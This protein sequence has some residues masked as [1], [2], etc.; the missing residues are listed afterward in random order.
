MLAVALLVAVAAFGVFA[1]VAVHRSNKPYI[2][3][4]PFEEQPARMP[5]DYFASG[6]SV[7]ILRQLAR[8]ADLRVL[9]VTSARLFAQ[10]GGSRDVARSLGVTH[11]LEGS[12]R[13]Q[14][15][16]V[17]VSAHLIRADDRSEVWGEQYDRALGEIFT[18]QQD[19]TNAVAQ[20][21]S[22][23][24]VQPSNKSPTAQSQVYDLYLQAGAL[25]R[26]RSE[27]SITQARSLLIDAVSKDP[28][29]AAGW[30]A[31]S[32]ATILLA[33][34]PG[35]YGS[36]P[37]EAARNEAAQ[38]A[39][40]AVNLDGDLAAAHA[41]SGLSARTNQAAIQQLRQAIALEPQQ[42]EFHEWLAQA[43]TNA[44][45]ARE[46]LAEY[47]LAVAF[48]PLWYPYAERLIRQLAFMGEAGDIERVVERFSDASRSLRDRDFL[49]LTGYWVQGELF[50]AA[51]VG[52]RILQEAP[53]DT[54]TASRMASLY[55]AIGDRNTA[56]A[57]LP[58]EAALK[59]AII[60]RNAG[61]IER[62]AREQPIEF[63]R[64]ELSGSRGGEVL[65]AEGRGAFLLEMFASRYGTVDRFWTQ[66]RAATIQC[67]PALIVA[68]REAGRTQDA[69]EL[70]KR[71]LRHIDA[72]IQTGAVSTAWSF[73][74]AQQY[75]L[76]G[77]TSGAL[78]EIDRLMRANWAGMLQPPFVPLAERIAFR[79]LRSESRL[80]SVQ[81]Q[82]NA[83]ISNTRARLQSSADL[84]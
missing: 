55:A 17:F 44:G 43:Y 20:R 50:E 25:M 33:D 49:E 41:A 57:T 28:G 63:W 40:R 36:N 21:L 84:T 75:A 22:P 72:D 56:L 15:D 39:E 10:S 64:E 58:V 71:V 32:I 31:L 70:N 5:G 42:A 23:R 18:L 82:L 47:R 66:E 38:H 11:I 1:Y 19:I 46:A 35:S 78:S 68:F 37:Y 74:R 69:T 2:A 83:Q 27:S 51:Q 6:M 65:T 67:A 8:N 9:G 48:E 77:N 59:R 12:V 14:G 61:E 52:S 62:I 53:D 81:R 73:E 80:R 29:Y 79:S 30:A 60:G 26:D 16:R 76:F 13:S 24:F 4:L 7:E 54:E 3:V 34:H 45:R